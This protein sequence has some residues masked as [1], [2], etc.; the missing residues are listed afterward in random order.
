MTPA[1][2]RLGR[3]L[4]WAA[5]ALTLAG[6]YLGFWYG[7][8]ERT[9]VPEGI[10]G[11]VLAADRFPIRF[12]L[13]HPHQNLGAVERAVPDFEQWLGAVGR[14]AGLPAPRIPGFG[15][16]RMPP[17]SGL[18]IATDAEGQAFVAAAEVHSTIAVLARLAGKLAS[19]PWL[20]GGQ[21]ELEGGTATVGWEGLRGWWVTSTGESLPAVSSTAEA[22]GLVAPALAW[23]RTR[24]VGLLPAGAIQ[25]GRRDGQLQ[26]FLEGSPESA[27]LDAK[28]LP[29][30]ERPILVLVAPPEFGRDGPGGLVLWAGAGGGLPGLAVLNGPGGSWELPGEDLLGLA[31]GGPATA[32]AGGLEIRAYDQPTAERTAVL[33][34][35]LRARSSSGPI[36]A[37]DAWVDPAPAGR[38][39]R[40]VKELL[41]AM[42]LFGSREVQRWRDLDTALAPLSGQGPLTLHLSASPA[43]L[44]LK[45]GALTDPPP[46]P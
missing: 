20:A 27:S 12:W 18:A 1:P 9:G 3:R 41:T 33:I 37:L 10:A 19:N 16:F 26:A 40:R 25:I 13:A 43:A 8:R 24:G 2:R 36:T 32:R 22:A 6:S 45:L 28:D 42:P 14:L 29:A 21:V 38:E 39:V 30:G 23:A 46:S 5:L 17:A 4:L 44:R 31:G 15:P 34:S 11:R 7:P 35:R